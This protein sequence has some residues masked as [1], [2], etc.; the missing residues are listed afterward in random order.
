[1]RRQ[2][3]AAPDRWTLATELGV[4]VECLTSQTTPCPTFQPRC[5]Y[6]L[7]PFVERSATEEERR[8]RIISREA[9]N[10]ALGEMQRS[11]PKEAVSRGT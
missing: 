5:V 2:V 9:L 8:A 1:M 3:T 4:S 11:Y 7:T 6:V 10:R